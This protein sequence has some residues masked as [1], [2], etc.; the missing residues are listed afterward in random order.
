ML[1]DPN[2]AKR[3]FKSFEGLGAF[4]PGLVFFAVREAFDGDTDDAVK[5]GGSMRTDRGSL[6]RALPLAMGARG[7]LCG[8]LLGAL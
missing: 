5:A 3:S 6:A 7:C 4:L 2:T 1:S 8:D